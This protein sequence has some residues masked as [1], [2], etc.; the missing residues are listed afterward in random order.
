MI[1]S[2]ITVT[3]NNFEG[4]RSTGKS[5]LE[6]D[7]S[8]WEW[9]IIDGN[10]ND[11]TKE[12]LAGIELDNCKWISE[13][14][15]GIFDAMNKGISKSSGDYLIFMN[16][17]DEFLNPDTLNDVAKE[18]LKSSIPPVFVY[19]DAIDISPDGQQY[20]KRAKSH[21]SLYKT[22]FTSHQS[23]FFE[24]RFGEEHQI[25]YPLKYRITGD[26]AYIAS[27]FKHITKEN[28]ILYLGFPICRFLL[29]GTNEI[30]RFKALKEDF[31]IR[32]EII[33]LDFFKASNLYLLHFI[34]TLLKR[35]IPALAKNLRY[36]KPV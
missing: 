30:H 3:W 4:L 16:A 25:R 14:D 26:Y 22:M 15:K 17:G 9:I 5:L 20:L 6:Q 27:Y 29:G 13:P 28:K 34:H 8:L 23:M 1:F 2:V 32:R 11:G 12:W 31:M 36:K 7:Q 21:E 35:I 18:L 10:S 24:R 19:G 33:G